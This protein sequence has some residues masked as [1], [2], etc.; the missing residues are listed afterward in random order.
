MSDNEALAEATQKLQASEAKL[1]G[2]EQQ[3]LQKEV[4]G[5]LASSLAQK[6]S[7]AAARDQAK[8]LA[9]LCEVTAA[10]DISCASLGS[11]GEDNIAAKHLAGDASYLLN[12]APAGG[13]GDGSAG[14]PSAEDAK[15]ARAIDDPEYAEQWKA[16]DAAGYRAAWDKHLAEAAKRRP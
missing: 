4:E 5:R 16:E 9:P 6:V 13:Q 15:L 12:A 8:L 3:L 7:Y 14:N 1:A 2:L 10:G 11:V